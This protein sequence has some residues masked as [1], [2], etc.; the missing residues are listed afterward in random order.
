MTALKPILLFAVSSMLASCATVASVRHVEVDA[1]KNAIAHDAA[2]QESAPVVGTIA[3]F[4]GGAFPS[5]DAP[6]GP[7]LGGFGLGVKL[8]EQYRIS[9]DAAFSET[10]EKIEQLPALKL[11]SSIYGISASYFPIK[12]F[13]LTLEPALHRVTYARRPQLAAEDIFIATKYNLKFGI[14]AGFSV[15]AFTLEG[16]ALPALMMTDLP[17]GLQSNTSQY[18][19]RLAYNISIPL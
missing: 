8:K 5:H 1:S 4:V 11:Y 12:W 18:Q 6:Q 16:R 9:F 17:S 13:Y 15:G 10:S 3:L 14:G 2:A 7:N 19:I